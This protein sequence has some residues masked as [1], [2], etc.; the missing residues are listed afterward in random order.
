MPKALKTDPAPAAGTRPAPSAVEIASWLLA[1]LTLFLVL[2]LHLLSALLGGLAVYELVHIL[3]ARLHFIRGPQQ[4]GK[5]W[6]VAI[7]AVLVITALTLAVVGVIAFSRGRGGPA[8]GLPVL[9]GQMADILE[10]AKGRL[11][12]GIATEIPDN[13]EDLKNAGVTWLRVHAGE[14]QTFGAQIGRSF[15]HALIGMIIGALVSLGEVAK[16]GSRGPLAEALA[17][18]SRRLG[19]AFRRIVFAQVRI[20]ALNTALTA[21]YLAVLLPV[22]GVKLPLIKTLIL[23]TFLAGLLPVVGNLISNT[24]IVVVSLSY[25]L[26]AALGALIFLIV[27]HKLEY[28][29]NARIVGS[30]IKAKAWELLL[31]MLVMEAAFGMAGLVAAPIYYAYLKEELAARGLL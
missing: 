22:L 31:A 24:V 20:S 6:A 3:G 18:R 13:A 16:A 29:V 10:T 12:P 2:R 23:L 30:E 15:L 27:I 21:L 19:E 28:F 7:L 8:A 1:A 25:S 11:P 4:A 9:L 14:L 17:E 26:G 5:R